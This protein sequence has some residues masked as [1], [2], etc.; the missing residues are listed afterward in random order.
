MLY[1]QRFPVLALQYS[2]ELP[3][4]LKSIVKVYSAQ[5]LITRETPFFETVL[6]ENPDP[7]VLLHILNT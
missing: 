4:D 5:S 2:S 7:E 6:T 1:A 3:P